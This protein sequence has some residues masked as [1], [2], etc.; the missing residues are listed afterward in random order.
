MTEKL[1]NTGTN[2]SLDAGPAD[3]RG[4]VDGRE[5][6]TAASMRADAEP[7][8]REP[9]GKPPNPLEELQ[10]RVASLED[11]L[12]RARADYQNLQ[13]R[14]AQELGDAVRYA[15]AELILSLLGVLD[16]F[17]RSLE[18]AKSSDTPASVADGV[19]LIYDNLMKVL[20]A[21]GLELIDAV[22]KPFDPHVHEAM[23][24]QPSADHPPGTVTAELAKGYLLRERVLRPARVVVSKVPDAN[25]RETQAAQPDNGQKSTGA[26]KKESSKKKRGTA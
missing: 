3:E 26:G 24:Q 21:H 23:M 5:E 12:L 17:E 25:A 13:R 10:G 7:A 11:S 2:G 8:P 18:A 6:D 19:R 14:G 22:G 4:D 20:Q 16:D 15:N 9:G 1:K